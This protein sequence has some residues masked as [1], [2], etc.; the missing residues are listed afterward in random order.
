M[1]E[2]KKIMP[3]NSCRIKLLPR[4]I[5]IYKLIRKLIR[6]LLVPHRKGTGTT[7]EHTM[8]QRL[9][10]ELNFFPEQFIFTN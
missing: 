6:K 3:F 8:S 9:K 4:T 10:L 1:S 7:Y 5:Y 2:R